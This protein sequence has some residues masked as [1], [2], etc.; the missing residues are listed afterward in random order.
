MFCKY[1]GRE[2]SDKDMFCSG[3]GKANELQTTDSTNS[4]SQ[5]PPE[6]NEVPQNNVSARDAQSTAK[7]TIIIG[8][9]CSLIMFGI[10]FI[11]YCIGY[12]S[13]EYAIDTIKP[14]IFVLVV[15]CF[16]GVSIIRTNIKQKKI[17]KIKQKYLWCTSVSSGISGVLGNCFFLGTVGPAED[18]NKTLLKIALWSILFIVLG[19]GYL[20]PRIRKDV[21]YP[22]ITLYDILAS[23]LACA[24]SF[25][26]ILVPSDSLGTLYILMPLI[27]CVVICRI[28]NVFGTSNAQ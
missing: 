10:N 19:I 11:A 2:I 22:T 15:F 25:L 13:A 18:E 20:I 26:L 4:L 8:V 21:A 24:S 3:C 6:Q 1:C 9:C 16:S 28:L 7:D 12:K 14:V 27:I 5:S 23:E 17:Y